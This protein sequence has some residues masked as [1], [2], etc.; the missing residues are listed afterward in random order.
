MSLSTKQQ[1]QL[2]AIREYTASILA[3]DLSGH[4]MEHIRRVVTLTK[5]I[6][7]TE[8]SAN[9]F[10]ALSG[11]YLHDTIDDKLVENVTVSKKNLKDFLSNENLN[12]QEITKIFD[13]IERISFKQRFSNSNKTLSLEAKIVQDA[14]RLDAI[15]AMGIVR[16][17]YY[18]GAKGHVIHDPSIQPRTIHSVAE[19]RKNTTAINHFYEKLL[20]LKDL[21]NTPYAKKLAEKRHRFMCEFLEEFNSEWSLNSL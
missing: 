6:C 4:D 13:I 14:D 18:G 21:M 8:P 20:L 19:Y 5:Q 7:R 16:T 15:G 11:A 2:S 9:L 17:F 10:I 12:S 1:Q 3:H